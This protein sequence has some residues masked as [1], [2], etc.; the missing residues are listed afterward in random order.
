[1]KFKI[2]PIKLSEIK[3]RKTKVAVRVKYRYLALLPEFSVVLGVSMFYPVGTSLKNVNRAF[4]PN[5][6]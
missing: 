5:Q 2:K 3:Y 4:I 1:M 6:Y